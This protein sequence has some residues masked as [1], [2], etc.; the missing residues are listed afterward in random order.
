LR[1]ASHEEFHL[2]NYTLSE[3]ENSSLQFELRKRKKKTAAVK[4]EAK[5]VEDKEYWVSKIGAFIAPELDLPEESI[6]ERLLRLVNQL[7]TEDQQQR[8]ILDQVKALAQELV[9]S[10]KEAENKVVVVSPTSH[11]I[12][13]NLQQFQSN[14]SKQSNN[15]STFT[16]SNQSTN[17]TNSQFGSSIAIARGSPLLT[18]KTPPSLASQYPV[19]K[20]K[21]KILQFTFYHFIIFIDLIVCY[22]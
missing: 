5:T 9:D 14:D 17:S 3:S 19:E 8:R 7:K 11:L 21:S 18:R 1:E 6:Q 2:K 16:H 15:S 4:F 13:T 20:V 12:S 22:F 10:A